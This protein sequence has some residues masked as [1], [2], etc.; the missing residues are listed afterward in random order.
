MNLVEGDRGVIVIDPLKS[1][2]PPRRPPGLHRPGPRHRLTL[3]NDALT[4]RTVTDPRTPA[5]LT[6]TL[7]KPEPLAVLAGRVLDTIS[8]TG[9]PA[10]LSS[11]QPPVLLLESSPPWGE[12]FLALQG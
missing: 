8:T 6:V 2:E 9:S 5:G 10:L 11:A 7:T 4:H 1:A 3:H 12:G